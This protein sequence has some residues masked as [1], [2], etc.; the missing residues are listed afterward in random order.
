MKFTFP[1]ESTPLDGYIIKRAIHRGGFGEVYYA[2]SDAGKEVA[3]K[4]LNNNLDVELR[5]VSQCLNLKHPNLVTIFDIRTDGDGDHWIVM[6]YV[7]GRSLLQLLDQCPN[8]FSV[9]DVSEWLSGMANGLAYLHDR[10]IVHRDLKPAN[11]FREHGIVKIGDVGLSKFISESRRSAQTQSVGTVYYMAP[12]VGR[13]RYGR[14]VDVYALGVMLYEMLTGWVPFDGETTA[15]ILMKHLSDRPNLSVLPAPLQPVIAAALE[16]DPQKRIADAMEL[17]SR[18]LGALAGIDGR[19]TPQPAEIPRAPHETQEAGGNEDAGRQPVWRQAHHWFASTR[20]ARFGDHHGVGVWSWIE[21]RW[22]QTPLPL[23]WLLF[24]VALVLMARSRT[25]VAAFE[26][27]AS[28]AMVGG[29]AWA[30]YRAWIWSGHTSRRVTTPS[31]RATVEPAPNTNKQVLSAGSDGN[32]VSAT[33]SHRHGRRV[34]RRFVSFTPETP[35]SIP[36]RQRLA[37]LSSSMAMAV[38]CTAVITAGMTMFMGTIADPVNTGF[39]GEPASVGLFGLTTLAA[40][41]ALLALTKLWEGRR[42]ENSSK[43]LLLLLLGAAVGAVAD[44]V[45]SSLLAELPES[46]GVFASIGNQPLLDPFDQP[47]SVAWMV[48][49]GC[50]FALRR[51]WW[52]TDSFRPHRFRLLSSLM[53]LTLG[54]LLTLLFQ[55]SSLWG[56]TLALAISC[57]VQL[58]AV[59]TVPEHRAQ[60]IEPAGTA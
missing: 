51:W 44:Q 52:H 2:L 19:S 10:G 42:I 21:A 36:M 55:F 48:F 56:T 3:L 54:Y 18:F 25:G 39:P 46:A 24:G 37:E 43:R 26:V 6:E 32:S 53:T 11:V 7:A 23:R 58:S 60:R 8:G 49:F 30:V 45:D 47:T 59:W 15:E 33:V 27:F 38:L 5:G 31:S 34:A 16:K 20:P 28:A 14:E 29:L 1:P 22:S 50:L 35:R 40:S 41:W 13:G 9:G 57:V 4:L 12:E 17:E